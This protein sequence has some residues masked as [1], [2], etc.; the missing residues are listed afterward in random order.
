MRKIDRASREGSG[1]GRGK[2]DA[3][4]PGAGGNKEYRPNMPLMNYSVETVTDIVERELRA[5]YEMQM[6]DCISRSCR[7]LGRR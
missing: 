6:M 3:S 2:P 4:L 7:R 5:Q 1:G